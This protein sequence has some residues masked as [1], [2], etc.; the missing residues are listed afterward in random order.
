MQRIYAGQV[1]TGKYTRSSA[2][3]AVDS[4]GSS[5]FFGQRGTG[6]SSAFNPWIARDPRQPTLTPRDLPEEKTIIAAMWPE[7][8]R[9]RTLPVGTCVHTIL[10][11]ASSCYSTR[12]RSKRISRRFRKIVYFYWSWWRDRAERINDSESKSGSP[13]YRRSLRAMITG[14]KRGKRT[15]TGIFI[16][17]A[18]ERAS[19]GWI[20][21]WDQF[22]SRSATSCCWTGRW[23]FWRSLSVGIR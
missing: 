22:V 10:L 3:L 8:S 1:S 21:N 19:A 18:I 4:V 11:K 17:R 23:S 9:R 12:P 15:A 7:R 5:C 2:W 14:E 6:I 13:G 20:S 16:P